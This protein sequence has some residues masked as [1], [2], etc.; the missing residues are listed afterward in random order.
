M[1]CQTPHESDLSENPKQE[2]TRVESCTLN[3]SIT[4][5]ETYSP[6]QKGYIWLASPEQ[7]FHNFVLNPV[8]CCSR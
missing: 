6:R 1:A 4:S 3:L 7:F 8:P 5:A 2:A